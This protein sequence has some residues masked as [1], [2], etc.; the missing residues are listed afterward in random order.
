M[1]RREK[2]GVV[3]RER[4]VGVRGKRLLVAN[5]GNAGSGLDGESK[6]GSDKELGNDHSAGAQK[7]KIVFKPNPYC[8]PKRVIFEIFEI[9]QNTVNS[10]FNGF[11]LKSLYRIFFTNC[12]IMLSLDLF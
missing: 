2:L 8:L 12:T 6:V 11:Y 3:R 9:Q 5:R 4:L 1:V 7:S 10:I